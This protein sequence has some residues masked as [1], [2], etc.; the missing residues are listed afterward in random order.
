MPPLDAP[1]TIG[2][3]SADTGCNIETI[4]YYE[5]I[6]LIEA[7][8]RSGGGY[9]LYDGDHAQRVAFIKRGRELGFALKQIR[10][11]LE[12]A[13][14][15]SRHS[16]AEVKQLVQQHERDVELKIADLQR[17]LAALRVMSAH[18]DGGNGPAEDC[19]ILHALNEGR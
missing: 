9:R 3:L 2:R 10:N 8:P 5:K 14:D 4:R 6:G 12:I 15:A 19:P 13:D 11:L 18:C 17:L 7:P 16:R 1:L